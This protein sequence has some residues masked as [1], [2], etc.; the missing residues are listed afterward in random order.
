MAAS[1][2]EPSL[3][4]LMCP[5]SVASFCFAVRALFSLTALPDMK[6]FR[7]RSHTSSLAK[8]GSRGRVA[9]L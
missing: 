6:S 9:E 5:R 1:C 8:T 3:K 2:P 7:A 4:V